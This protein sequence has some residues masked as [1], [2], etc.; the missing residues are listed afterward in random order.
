NDVAALA[1]VRQDIDVPAFAPQ[2][3]EVGERRL[4]ARQDDEHGIARQRCSW[5]DQHKLDR[6]LYR[7]RVEIVE[8]GDARQEG[9]GDLYRSGLSSPHPNPPPLAGE[10]AVC[11]VA[12]LPP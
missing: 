12:A 6:G 4:R 11:G 5:P 2:T 9:D 8:I 7:E 10:G 1:M 3:S